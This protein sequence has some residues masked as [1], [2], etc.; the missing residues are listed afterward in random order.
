[1]HELKTKPK[2]EPETKHI[3]GGFTSQEFADN[4][5]QRLK[6]LQDEKAKTIYL[7]IGPSGSGKTTLGNCLK[8]LGIPEIVSHTTRPKRKGESL[9]NPYYFV[10][11]SDFLEIDMIEHT[12]YNGFLY[13]TSVAEIESK[14][15]DNRNTY[16][17][18]N[19]DGVRAFKD[20]YGEIV[21]V[22]YVYASAKQLVENMRKR[23]DDEDSIAERIIHAYK[24]GEF[25]NIELADYC[26]INKGLA[27]AIAQLKAIVEGF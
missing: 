15:S 19:S 22:I 25:D 14:L 12:E 17:I 13:G 9:G 21:K 11:L 5:I 6:E 2:P 1:M 24:T 18:V 10:T 20:Q 16:A 7:L 23:G 8:Q 27:K 4:V 3:V 26:I